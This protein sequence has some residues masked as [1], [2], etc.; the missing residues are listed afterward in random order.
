M[1]DSSEKV[2][3]TGSK[4]YLNV[5]YDRK[6]SFV[7]NCDTSML[8]TDTAADKESKMNNILNSVKVVTKTRNGNSYNESGYKSAGLTN[9]V[10]GLD[11]ARSADVTNIVKFKFDLSDGTKILYNGKVYEGNEEIAVSNDDF[12]QVDKF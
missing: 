3:P 12:V 2:L 9:K 4:Y 5:Y 1:K 10:N 6:Q 8:D 7:V 11:Y